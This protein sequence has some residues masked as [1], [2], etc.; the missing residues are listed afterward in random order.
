[1]YDDEPQSPPSN[2][3]PVL[4]RYKWPLAGLIAGLM[5][6]A[7]IV[8][9]AIPPVYR[10][11]AV[12]M[13][14]T[15]QIPM[16]LVQSTVTAAASEQIG[17]I[18]QRVMTR[19]NL[20]EIIDKYPYF[21]SQQL[22]DYERD[23]LLR[24]FVKNIELNVA[25]AQKGRESV[26][27]GFTVSYANKNPV[28]SQQVTQDLVSLFLSE[29]VRARTARASETTEF[30][31][32]EAAKI[33]SELDLIEAKVAD[34]KRENKDALP[35]HLNLYIGM[36]EDTRQRLSDI[37]RDLTIAQEQQ[38][39]LNTQLAL[40]S[41]Q[42]GIPVGSL[43]DELKLQYQRML[44]Q[45]TPQHPEVVV[46]R[47]Q[48]AALEK[49]PESAAQFQELAGMREA[50]KQ[51]VNLQLKIDDLQQVR[52]R[53]QEKLEDIQNRIIKIPQVER[54]FVSIKRDY[55]TISSQYD[56]IVAK[57]QNAEIAES[58]EQQAKAERFVL[59]EAPV[60]PVYPNAPDRMKM[61][62]VASAAAFG[63][64]LGLAF[65]FGFL[66]KSVRRP[67]LLPDLGAP[68][69]MELPYVPTR[70]ERERRQLWVKRLAVGIPVALLV[71]LLLVHVLVAPLGSVAEA[72]AARFVV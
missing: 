30:L 24:R 70:A 21:E 9:A 7:F 26:A 45:Y 53:E 66:D 20:Q 50:R 1:M 44:M 5:V 37:D 49:D 51:L 48:I 58:L 6:L 12:V 63:L 28:I 65:V 34:Y 11:E 16:D 72:I 62:T 59:L 69:L 4:L 61:L 31:R 64:P 27:I 47:E 52:T 29:N 18:E 57:M 71:I 41:D 17:I 39:I 19:Q 3:V 15:Q 10:A 54:A 33:R 13:V 36:R 55:E 22:S 35:E 8:I 68:L 40:G 60:V 23:Q 67:E 46:L 56:A 42:S 32:A 2:I 25:S 43:L 14:E 38:R